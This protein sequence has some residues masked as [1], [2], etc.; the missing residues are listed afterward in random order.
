MLQLKFGKPQAAV[1][2]ATELG[3]R[4]KQLQ[5][6]LAKD[7]PPV[8]DNFAAKLCAAVRRRVGNRA[9]VSVTATS[10][11]SSDDD[12]FRRKLTEATKRL[13]EKRQNQV[14]ENAEKERS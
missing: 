13:A 7:P 6:D 8:V 12:S 11:A 4:V 1:I 3:Q 5:A 10:S 2:T 14:K 9:R